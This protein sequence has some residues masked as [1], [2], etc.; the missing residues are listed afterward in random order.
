MNPRLDDTRHRARWPGYAAAVWGFVFAVPS[1]YWAMGGTA[2]VE[3]TISPQLVELARRQDP[4][5]LAVLW[6]TGVLKV[7]GGMLGLALA[8][9]RPWGPGMNR[10][11]QL[12]AWGAGVLLAWHGAQF[13][14]QGLLVQAGLV[15]IPPAALPILRWYTYLWGPWFVAG[16]VAFMLAARAH[17]RTVADRRY[18][19]MAGVA[20][21]LGALVLSVVALMAGIG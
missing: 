16:G 21:G 18:P 3:S 12:M 1:F 19:Q 2:G 11:L 7:V 15:E 8:R 9:R 20:G 13:I 10:L 4:G 6:V 17:L 5:M 14:V